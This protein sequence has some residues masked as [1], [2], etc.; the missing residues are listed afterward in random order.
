MINLGITKQEKMKICK[1]FL[2]PK[3]LNEF[4]LTNITF[5]DEAL[6][7]LIENYSKEQ[8]VRNLKHILKKITSKINLIKYCN[9]KDINK[10]KIRVKFPLNISESFIKKLLELK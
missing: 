1:K 2:I 5:K 4:N 10:Q 6:S 9:N 7:F 8:G 3:I